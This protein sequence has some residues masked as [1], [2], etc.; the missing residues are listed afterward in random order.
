MKT[1]SVAICNKD[2]I[3]LTNYGTYFH[4]EDINF[5]KVEE[6]CLSNGYTAYGYYFGTKSNTLTTSR[7][8]TILKEIK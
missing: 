2:G 5:D 4:L 6:T 7:C 1:Y 8:R 3:W